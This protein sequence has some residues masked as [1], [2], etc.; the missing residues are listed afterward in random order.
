MCLSGPKGNISWWD[1][2]RIHYFGKVRWVDGGFI[3]VVFY[4]IPTPHKSYYQVIL[5]RIKEVVITVFR[6]NLLLSSHQTDR[7][8]ANLI[9]NLT[10]KRG[11]IEKITNIGELSA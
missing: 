2:K 5:M 9:G 6:I 1:R 8:C 11:K 3:V 4:A 10:T 7:G